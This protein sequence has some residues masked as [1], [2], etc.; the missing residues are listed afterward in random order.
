MRYQLTLEGAAGTDDT[1]RMPAGSRTVS[2]G[3]LKAIHARLLG[4]D[5]CPEVRVDNQSPGTVMV[6][7]RFVD[8]YAR[9]ANIVG[10]HL[11]YPEFHGPP[12]QI[13]GVISDIREDSIDAPPYPYVYNCAR[14]GGW[15]DPEYTIRAARRSARASSVDSRAG[16]PRRSEPRD[17]RRAHHGR[18]A[19]HRPRS[20]PHQR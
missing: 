2:P 13:V 18:V 19:G 9:G 15:P 7:R 5:W 20:P 14:A 10:R 4:G 6:N 3:Y 1:A 17:L 16:P 12:V 11:Q 8:V